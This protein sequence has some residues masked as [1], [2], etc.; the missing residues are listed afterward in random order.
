MM[1]AIASSDRSVD[2]NVLQ[3]DRRDFLGNIEGLRMIACSRKNSHMGLNR[4]DENRGKITV[5][6]GDL[7][8]NEK[9]IDRQTYAHH[10]VTGQ[11]SQ[12]KKF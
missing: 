5:E 4:I 3:P 1:P 12:P 11:K 7:L 10:M 6:D 8:V 9:N 2:G